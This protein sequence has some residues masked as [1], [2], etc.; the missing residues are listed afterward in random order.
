[1]GESRQLPSGLELAESHMLCFL[2]LK[3]ASVMGGIMSHP[4]I[5]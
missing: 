1:M 3:T 5:C 4:K 2:G